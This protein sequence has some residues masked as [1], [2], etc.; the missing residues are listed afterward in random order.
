MSTVPDPHQVGRLRAYAG[1]GSRLIS[2]E[3]RQTMY[4]LGGELR[5]R[6]WTLY[7]GNAPG[8]DQAFQTGALLVDQTTRVPARIFLPRAGFEQSRWD[9]ERFAEAHLVCGDDP[10]CQASLALHP[11]QEA[12]KV[13]ATR[14][15][16]ARNYRIIHGHAEWPRVRF[17]VCCADPVPGGVKGGTGQAV[18]VALAAGVPVVNIRVPGWQNILF[19]GIA[20]EES[21]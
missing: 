16:L 11:N 6:G 9:Y 13:T 7:S 8:S 4:Y 10:E 19:P 12:L 1:I 20:Y 18:R 14:R 17:V 2:E 3:E 15:L 5:R 21:R